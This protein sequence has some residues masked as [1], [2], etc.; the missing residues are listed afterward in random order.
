MSQPAPAKSEELS[1]E[2]I[3]LI[4]AIGSFPPNTATRS[5]P[6]W[7]RWSMPAGVGVGFSNWSKTP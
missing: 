3:D 2:L 7:P 4:G 5:S 6:S 1:K